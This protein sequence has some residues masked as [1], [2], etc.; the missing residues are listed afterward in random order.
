MIPAFERTKTVYTLGRAASV[1]STK[2]IN[3]YY[4]LIIL[5]LILLDAAHHF[6]CAAL[7]E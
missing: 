2:E 6:V 4:L 3:C 1:I 7:T 5:I